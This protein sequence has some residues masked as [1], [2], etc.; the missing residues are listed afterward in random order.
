MTHPDA[1]DRIIPADPFAAARA[2]YADLACE[3]RPGN[4]MEKPFDPREAPRPV[5]W[6]VV[7]AVLLIGL[8]LIASIH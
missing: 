3:D 1:I 6:I 4:P 5:L 8:S 7:G 2:R